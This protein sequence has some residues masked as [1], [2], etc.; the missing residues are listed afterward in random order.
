M[1]ATSPVSPGRSASPDSSGLR[2]NPQDS[3][4][5]ATGPFAPTVTWAAVASALSATAGALAASPAPDTFT[6]AR[7]A[8]PAG[9]TEVCHGRRL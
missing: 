6:R 8:T 5:P 9:V 4:V 1:T 3:R 2:R 7:F